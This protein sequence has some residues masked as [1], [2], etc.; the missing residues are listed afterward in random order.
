MNKNLLLLFTI[1][2]ITFSGCNKFEDIT[3]IKIENVKVVSFNQQGV[4]AIITATIKNPNAVGFTIYKSAMDVTLEGLDVGKANLTEKVKVKAKSETSH[5]F[6]IKS[7]F[8]KLSVTDLPKIFG[9]AM[10]KNVNVGLKGK[11]KVGKFYV[12]Y[13]IPVDIKKTVPLR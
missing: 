7:D 1:C 3:V 8:S 13:A 2:T 10:G 9:I 11:L 12:K 5:D 4:E 6:H